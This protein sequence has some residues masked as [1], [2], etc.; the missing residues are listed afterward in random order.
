MAYFWVSQS[1]SLALT[2]RI[3]AL[4]VV[5]GVLVAVAAVLRLLKKNHDKRVMRYTEHLKLYI[6]T[7]PLLWTFRCRFKP[8]N[9]GLFTFY[10]L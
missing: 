8:H 10:G 9:M 6:A 3:V 2:G 7:L 5:P 4:V 1:L